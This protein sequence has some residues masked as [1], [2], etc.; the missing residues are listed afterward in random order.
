MSV[1]KDCFHRGETDILPSF[2]KAASCGKVLDRI[3]QPDGMLYSGLTLLP[4]ARLV[5]E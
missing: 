2:D 4:A 3:G 1:L 5:T